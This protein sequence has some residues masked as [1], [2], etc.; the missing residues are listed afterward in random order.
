MSADA[1][2]NAVLWFS[3]ALLAC[4]VPPQPSEA[5]SLADRIFAGFLS[6]G[7]GFSNA[8][9]GFVV[10]V[11]GLV[12]RVG[13]P[14]TTA[15]S[16]K[17]AAVRD[18]DIFASVCSLSGTNRRSLIKCLDENN[19]DLLKPDW[20]NCIG[21]AKV[22]VLTVEDLY[23]WACSRLSSATELQ[24]FRNTSQCLLEGMKISDIAAG[25]RECKGS[26][27]TF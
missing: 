10:R 8:T 14:S 17:G 3:L 5:A 13:G 12:T 19:E 21:S 4:G 25:I 6:F 27:R 11:R 24:E 26:S 23:H 9:Q 16:N 18:I 15:A 7:R 22:E 2:R 20:Q 1:R